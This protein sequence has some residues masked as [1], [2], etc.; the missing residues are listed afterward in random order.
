MFLTHLRY[1]VTRGNKRRLTAPLL[2]RTRDGDQIEAETDF[3]SDGFTLWWPF[4]FLR[5]LVPQYGHGVESAVIHDKALKLARYSDA[6]ADRIFRQAL[7]DKGVNI[8]SRW[9]MW[10]G[11]RVGS[12][13]RWS[14]NW[15]RQSLTIGDW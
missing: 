12:G 3:I 7:E 13:W 1:A 14:K 4:F 2:Y 6:E 8:V 5:L 9:L 15:I 11:V 10:A